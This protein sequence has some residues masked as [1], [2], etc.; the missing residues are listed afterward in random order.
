MIPQEIW[1]N[2]IGYEEYYLVSNKGRIKRKDTCRVLKF[3]DNHGYYRVA[4]CKGNVV[5]RY[6]VHRIVAEAFIENPF[7]LPQINHKDE[8][9]KNN[10]VENLEWCTAAYNTHYGT[11]I[12]RN[13]DARRGV[14]LSEERK[15][16]ISLSCKGKTPPKHTEEGK[17]KMSEAAK[18][19]WE[20]RRLE[21]GL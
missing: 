11:G 20:R 13:S 21:Y 6:F 19:Q 9:K 8:N 18:K 14:P 4:L 7:N 16:K 10:C 5:K 1:H 17:R 12:K 15:R 2:V 3:A